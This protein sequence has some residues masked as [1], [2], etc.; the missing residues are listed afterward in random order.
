MLK[1]LTVIFFIWGINTS[2]AQYLTAKQKIPSGLVS[3]TSFIVNVT[4]DKGKLNGILKYSQPLPKGFTASNIDCKNGN[5]AFEDNTAKIIWL[6]PPSETS[7]T[8]SYQI[9]VP[10]NASGSKSFGGKI[11][12]VT[13]NNERRVFDFPLKRA[14][15]SNFNTPLI[16]EKKTQKPIIAPPV[17]PVIAVI[18]QK[19][20]NILKSENSKS[21]IVQKDFQDVEKKDIS[22]YL[23]DPK[24]FYRVQIGAFKS[25]HKINGVP[26][27]STFKINEITKHFSGNFS[28]YKAATGRKMMMINKGFKDAFVAEFILRNQIFVQKNNTACMPG[29]FIMGEPHICYV[30]WDLV[31][32]TN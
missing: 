28:S 29:E 21:S 25:D 23:N 18:S 3:G 12:Y 10:K 14:V 19:N 4:I 32:T 15:I 13:N 7:Y 30:W 11:I 26:E 8:I 16:T 20:K 24:I 22:G 9:T 5:F 17:K 1:H 27:Q 2:L 6:K 31:S